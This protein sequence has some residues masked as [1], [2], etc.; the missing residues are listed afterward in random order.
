VI[1]SHDAVV[2]EPSVFQVSNEACEYIISFCSDGMAEEDARHAMRVGVDDVGEHAVA[3][4]CNLG[5]RVGPVL[6]QYLATVWFLHPITS[7]SVLDFVGMSQH[8]DSERQFQYGRHTAVLVIW[9][10]SRVGHDTQILRAKHAFT[11]FP[12][13]LVAWIDGRHVRFR[14]AIV[15]VERYSPYSLCP[16][17]L[18]IHPQEIYNR[19]H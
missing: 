2:D 18:D 13:I 16:Q 15:L 9:S 1:L 7:P 14:Q 3:Y 19:H 8:W 5:G 17:L 10:P 11:M 6:E 4:Y 12:V